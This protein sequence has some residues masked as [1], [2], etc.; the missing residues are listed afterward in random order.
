MS[1]FCSTEKSPEQAL[2]HSM[3]IK[4][5]VQL[6]LIQAIDNMVFFPNTTRND[7]VAILEF[8]QVGPSHPHTHTCTHTHTH[9]LANP[10]TILTHVNPMILSLI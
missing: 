5:V 9:T 6:E 8:S 10:N 4:C 3:I 2:F 7:D 1:L